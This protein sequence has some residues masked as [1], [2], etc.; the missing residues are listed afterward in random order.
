[1]S[2]P[3]E[4]LDASAEIFGTFLASSVSIFP[5]EFPNAVMIIDRKLSCPAACPEIPLF[6]GNLPRFSVF[7]EV[8]RAK[9]L[10]EIS[11]AGYFGGLST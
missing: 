11:D 10:P 4:N 3:N 9:V 8:Q 5:G 1:V 6:R 2:S 7:K